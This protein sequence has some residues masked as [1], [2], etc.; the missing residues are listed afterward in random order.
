MIVLCHVQ[1]NTADAWVVFRFVRDVPMHGLID[2]STTLVRGN[3][4]TLDPPKYPVP[5]ITPFERDHELSDGLDHMT[6]RMLGDDIKA[7]FWM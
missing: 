6:A 4:H 2:S 7:V 3:I 1:S 5:P